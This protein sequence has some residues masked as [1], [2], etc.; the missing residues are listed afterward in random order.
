MGELLGGCSQDGSQGFLAHLP[1]HAPGLAGALDMAAKTKKDVAE[2]ADEHA[3][4]F[5]HD[6][7]RRHH[8]EEQERDEWRARLQIDLFA[9]GVAHG[10]H[11]ED[12]DQE[13]QEGQAEGGPAMQAF[14][15]GGEVEEEQHERAH[16][17]RR[18]RDRQADEVLVA[19][20]FG[21]L[22]EGVRNDVETR[23]TNCRAEQVNESDQPAD[24]LKDG[25]SPAMGT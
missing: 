18:R 6:D 22:Q 14:V 3:D 1:T 12:G 23:Q 15:L 2:A 13:Q 11:H 25:V 8:A 17:A 21:A 10:A 4:F 7:R 19:V 9:A 5:E 16:G 20:N 24:V